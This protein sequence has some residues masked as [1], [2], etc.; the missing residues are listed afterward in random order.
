L[1][2]VR[3]K[4]SRAAFTLVELL[5]VIGI[6]ALLI[7]ILLPTLAKAREQSNRTACLSNLQTL[8]RA[9]F[10]Y[11]ESNNGWLPNCN[12]KSV[13]YSDA[14]ATKALLSLNDN[15]VKSPAVFHCASDRDPIPLRI[16]TAD[17]MTPDSARVSYDFYSIYWAPKYGPK[18][19]HMKLAPL[20]WDLG[21]APDQK[22]YPEQNHGPLGGNV[23]HSDGHAAWQPAGNWDRGGWPNP[24]H[25]N[26]RPAP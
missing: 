19:H 5:V 20:A 3:S 18:L 1:L 23:V 14:G 25:T 24:A 17:I 6:I 10:L 2:K 16:V 22:I 21:V 7:G 13:F 4:P 12:P 15:F 8:G 9:M 26:Y 11:A